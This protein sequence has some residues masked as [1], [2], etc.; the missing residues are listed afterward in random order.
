MNTQVSQVLAHINAGKSITP[1]IAL[2]VY[3]IYRLSSVI[4]DIRHTGVK[5]DCLIKYDET[6]KQYGEYRLR[7]P[8]TLKAKVQVVRGRGIGLPRWVRR[9][10]LAEVIS[11]EAG[12]S[13]VRFTRGA[14]VGEFWLNDKEIQRAD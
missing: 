7:R 2:V 11:K 1:A 14:L 13:L 8:I 5:V 10:K 9:Q 3:G 12:A 4:E 6:G